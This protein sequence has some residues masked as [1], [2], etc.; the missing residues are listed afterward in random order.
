MPIVGNG[1]ERIRILNFDDNNEVVNKP[2]PSITAIDTRF[3][4]DPENTL[5]DV[6]TGIVI[7]PNFVLTAAHVIYLRAPFNQFQNRIRVSSSNNQKVLNDRAIGADNRDPGTNVNINSLFLPFF[8]DYKAALPGTDNENLFDIGLIELNNT[9][10]ISDAPPVGLTAFVAP[11]TVRELGI[12]IQTAGYAGDNV[13]NSFPTDNPNNNGI[14]DRNGNIRPRAELRFL[15]DFSVQARD[16]V[17][18]AGIGNE[19]TGTVFN[20]QGRRIQYSDN[21]DTVGGQS[22]SPV[23]HTLE[24]DDPRVLAVHSRGGGRRN[25]GTLID[26]EAYNLIMDEIEGDEDPALLP[27]N[28]IIGSDPLPRPIPLPDL[29]G[30][31]LIEGTYRKER[32]LGLTGNDTISGAGADDRLEGNEGNDE[33]DGG[34]G[35]DELEGNEGNDSLDGGAGDDILTGGAG[36]D[37]IN[38]GISPLPIINLFDRESDVAVYSAPIGEYNIETS[39]GGLFGSPIGGEE[40]TTITHLNGGIDGTD[41]LTNIEIL[42]FAGGAIP[43][44]SD[45]DVID[46]LTNFFGGPQDDDIV[47]NALDNTLRGEGGNDR[48]DGKAGN[49]TLDGGSGKDTLDGGSGNDLLFGRGQEDTLNG[50]LGNDKLFGNQ[51]KDRLSGGDGNDT[52]NGGLG[53]DLLFGQNQNDRVFGYQGRDILYGDNGADLVKGGFGN[54]IMYG[55]SGNDTLYGQ[56]DDDILYGKDQNDF[57][58]GAKGFDTLKGGRGNDIFSFDMYAPFE[59]NVFGEDVII[60]F[61]NGNDRIRLDKTTFDKISSVAG[62]GFSDPTDFE[63]VDLS[64]SIQNAEAVIVF[65]K[66][67]KA[68]YY[69]ENGSQPGLG[70]GG[71]IANFGNEATPATTVVSSLDASDFIISN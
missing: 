67:T 49:D 63:V 22:G 28:L 5:P 29:P 37:F 32:I 11:R 60:D 9:D 2:L 13:A 50:G 15:E 27:E 16:L 41:T 4:G 34:I 7:S 26:T 1:D 53:N 46:D 57:L 18:A 24:G 6:G 3:I 55:G 48:L 10:L 69:N 23:W 43:L 14:P 64:S 21:I 8:D 70:D 42:V 47:G 36:N 68:L 19:T 12:P 51:F 62:R 17:L 33:L 20:V 35:N 52:L 30:D 71:T 25:A 31:D 44:S 45:D 39:P 61:G 38:G 56:T 59:Q 54:D 66:A 65:D 58:T 40:V